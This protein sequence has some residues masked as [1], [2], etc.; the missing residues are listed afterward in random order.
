MEVE[1]ELELEVDADA[2]AE[3]SRSKKEEK[4]FARECHTHSTLLRPFEVA[5]GLFD[6]QDGSRL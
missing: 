6:V 2:D 4:C 3:E 5:L 1:V